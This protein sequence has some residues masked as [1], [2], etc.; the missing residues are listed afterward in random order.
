MLKFVAMGSDM[1]E[2]KLV[3]RAIFL[4]IKEA[5]GEILTS[6][7]YLQLLQDPIGWGR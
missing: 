6:K 7:V 2:K 3:F 1:H 4:G 5:R